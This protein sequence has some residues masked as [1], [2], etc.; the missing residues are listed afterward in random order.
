MKILLF[1]LQDNT[2]NMTLE[3]ILF[4]FVFP[5]GHGA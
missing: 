2:K 5:H 4:L 3:I 1:D